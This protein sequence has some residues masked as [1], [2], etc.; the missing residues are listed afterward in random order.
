MIALNS[1]SN[2]APSASPT[3][4]APDPVTRTPPMVP[5]GRTAS[6]SSSSACV[7]S[8]GPPLMRRYAVTSSGRPSTTVR[9]SRGGWKRSGRSL[10]SRSKRS[11]SSASP[12][13]A[14]LRLMQPM[15][16]PS[17]AMGSVRRTSG[18]GPADV[19]AIPYRRTGDPASRGMKTTS[20]SIERQS[21][22]HGPARRGR[23]PSPSA[24]TAVT[25]TPRVSPLGARRRHPPARR[26][27]SPMTGDREPVR[28]AGASLA[29]LSRRRPAAHPDHRT[30]GGPRE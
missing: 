12:T 9:P 13:R 8:A 7:A 6:R 25:L 30:C 1:F 14:A 11:R 22:A 17:E 26:R 23:R 18:G 19:T 5:A 29:S 20:V 21:P 16:M 3:R 10:R 15:S 2:A 27:T 4:R 28:P 24:P